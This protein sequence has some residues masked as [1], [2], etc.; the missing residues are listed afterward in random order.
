LESP[1]S[2]TSRKR[3]SDEKSAASARTGRCGTSALPGRVMQGMI[4]S[5]VAVLHF[6]PDGAS[7]EEDSRM[8][9]A[10]KGLLKPAYAG[11]ALALLGAFQVYSFLA[12]AASPLEKEKV[13]AVDGATA[14]AAE[15][16]PLEWRR[17]K[18][19]VLRF[20]SDETGY[21]TQ[22]MEAA[23]R[24]LDRAEPVPLPVTEA[25]VALVKELVATGAGA[26]YPRAAALRLAA[27]AEAEILLLGRIRELSIEDGVPKAALSVEAAD[28][29]TGTTVWKQ[30]V[31]WT[32]SFLERT[33]G[34]ISPMKR[35]ISW[36][37]FVVML[38][39]A[40]LPITRSI[41]KR[42]SNAA[43]AGVLAF[44][45]AVA[46]VLA[47][48]ALAGDLEAW[49]GAFFLVAAAF[50]FLYNAGVLNYLAGFYR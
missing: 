21:V 22:S 12:P 43:N 31:E 30:D 18:M 4:A 16:M 7:F 29:E 3:A 8:F 24:R 14:L 17:R 9:S 27:E 25:L 47:Y 44:F 40:C 50:G 39:W 36:V 46:L 33:V 2:S 19:L 32:P 10:A 20:A 11:G 5:G 15:A 1:L 38:P 23:V 45:T 41:L 48:V 42:E 35:A 28:T 6:H 26:G 13:R 37:L 34:R 49:A